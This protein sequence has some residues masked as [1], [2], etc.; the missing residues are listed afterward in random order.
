MSVS[1]SVSQSHCCLRKADGDKRR[2]AVS[3]QE[4]IQKIL[5]D[6]QTEKEKINAYNF[7]T[8]ENL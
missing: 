5:W 8:G 7:N 4:H 1:Q 3:T 6:L 2:D